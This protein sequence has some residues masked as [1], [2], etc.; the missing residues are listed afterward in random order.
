MIANYK[1]RGLIWIGLVLGLQIS[2]VP[3]RQE[4]RGNFL[5]NESPP[6][7]LHFSGQVPWRNQLVGIASWY[8]NGFQGHLTASGQ[9]YDMYKMTAAHKTLPLGS[10]VRVTNLS[11][12][13][14]VVVTINDRGPYV[15]GRII[16]LSKSAAQALGMLPTGTAKVK[17]T[18]L[19][20]P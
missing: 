8:G 20:I 3:I 19:K 10:V 16:D 6:K 11:N 5:T 1:I 14:S 15:P 9:V 18:I 12:G 7:Y 2:C 4:I 17:I 13:K